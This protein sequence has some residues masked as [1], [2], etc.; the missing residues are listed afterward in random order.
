MTHCL[1]DNFQNFGYGLQP[2]IIRKLIVLPD[3]HWGILVEVRGV[4]LRTNDSPKSGNSF[5]RS[6]MTSYQNKNRF[7]IRS[8]LTRTTLNRPRSTHNEALLW[9]QTRELSDYE[10]EGVSK[11]GISPVNVYDAL[12]SLLLIT[13]FSTWRV[14]WTLYQMASCIS[15]HSCDPN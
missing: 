5:F 10:D 4:I 11:P 13:T 3:V 12:S 8:F 1:K 9:H 2:P 14:N 15:L 7:L 6:G